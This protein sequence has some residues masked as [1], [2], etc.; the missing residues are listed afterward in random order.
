[1][2]DS[3]YLLDPEVEAILQEVAKDPDSVLL[4]VDRPKELRVL[5]AGGDTVVRSKTGLSSAEKQLL[6]VHRDE[7][8]YLL[9]LAYYELAGKLVKDRERGLFFYPR[10]Y[11]AEHV[12]DAEVIN[13]LSRESSSP[14][15]DNEAQ[16]VIRLGLDVLSESSPHMMSLAALSLRLAPSPA[17]HSYVAREFILSGHWYSAESVCRR[18]VCQPMPDDHKASCLAS[19]GTVL[20]QTRRMEES[21]ETFR[22]ATGLAVGPNRVFSWIA[23]SI[24][25]GC[26][27]QAREAIGIAD[28]HWPSPDSEVDAWISTLRM[29]RAAHVSKLSRPQRLESLSLLNS[30][31]GQPAQS[32]LRA[33]MVEDV[34]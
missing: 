9:R 34:E 17:A 23:L 31:I 12:S 22:R 1:M 20:A 18:L 28:A 16:E 29:Q 33:L 30:A 4:R 25:T 8:A 19:L 11:H 27:D 13:R 15:V 3:S 14:C 24:E 2:S 26:V 32:V 10:H 21:R 6:E 7:A 5:L